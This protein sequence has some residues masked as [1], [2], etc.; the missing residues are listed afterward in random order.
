MVYTQAQVVE[1]RE[2]VAAAQAA[3]LPPAGVVPALASCNGIHLV[4][5]CSGYTWVHLPMRNCEPDF[6]KMAEAILAIFA[7]RIAFSSLWIRS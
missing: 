2:G 7:A 5:G 1:D 6:P 3:F 4:G